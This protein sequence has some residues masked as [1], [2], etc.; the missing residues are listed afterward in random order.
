[1]AKKARITLPLMGRPYEG[2]ELLLKLVARYVPTISELDELIR[3]RQQTVLLGLIYYSG[4]DDILY[5]CHKQLSFFE[6]E[7]DRLE[8]TK[9][10]HELY[11]YL[12][13][14]QFGMRLFQYLVECSYDKFRSFYWVYQALEIL[15]QKGEFEITL[16]DL[17]SILLEKSNKRSSKEIY[18]LLI[19]CGA[20]QENDKSIRIIPSFFSVDFRKKQ[21]DRLWTTTAQLLESEGRL[22]YPDLRL[23][24]TNDYPSIDW[25]DIEADFRSRLIL[26]RTRASEFADGVRRDTTGF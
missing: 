6:I 23:R 17:K 5:F 22:L 24:L 11:Q 9:K 7:N 20:I 8:L 21:L 2:I 3:E 26:S 16:N 25:Q 18:Q 14:P 19:G 4:K 1:M 13:T 10:G 12:D 15:A